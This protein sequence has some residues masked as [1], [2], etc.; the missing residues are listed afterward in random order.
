MALG[1]KLGKIF[2]AIGSG[3]S[4]VPGPWSALGA[5]VG[6]AGGIASAVDQKKNQPEE[7]EP[8]EAGPTAQLVTEDPS[9]PPAGQLDLQ[10]PTL[11]PTQPNVFQPLSSG[12]GGESYQLQLDREIADMITRSYDGG[13]YGR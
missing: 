13:L 1:S 9:R 8:P 11:Q 2:G 12:P 6:A 3:L 7:P 5:V 4:F 10:E